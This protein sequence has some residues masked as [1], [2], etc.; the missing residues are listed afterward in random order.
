MGLL[1][2]STN[3][4][5]RLRWLVADLNSYFASCEQQENQDLRGKPIAVAPLLSNTTCAIAASYEAKAY[6]VKTGTNIGEAR[7]MCPGLIVRHPA[8]SSMSNITTEF[9]TRL[10]A[11]FPSSTS[12]RLMRWPV[13][14]IAASRP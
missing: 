10:R 8:Q 14:W 11:A 4:G 12:C 5:P 7:K 1:K 2:A 6:G 9:W 3:E 13:C